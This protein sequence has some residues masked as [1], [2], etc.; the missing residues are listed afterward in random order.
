MSDA[1]LSGAAGAPA[2]PWLRRTIEV[3]FPF[4]VAFAMGALVLEVT[5]R[6]ALTTYV[7]LARSALGGPNEIAN[8]LVAATPIVLTGVA[9]A[10]AFR[11]GVFNV[12]VEGSV[13]VGAFAAAWIGFTA[14]ALPAPLLIGLA[15]L[16][17]CLAGLLWAVAPALV[18]VW[19]DVNEVVT[20]LM[21][22]YVAILLTSYLVNFHFLA[23][24]VAN[25]MSPLVA[26]HL[27]SI[28][29]PTQLTLAF[30]LAVAVVIAYGVLF[31]STT[32]GYAMR[33]VGRSGP[34]ARAS[35]IG[36]WRVVLAAMLL[37]GLVGG[38]AGGL[39]VLSV[40]Y[41][42][43][44]NF[45]PGYGFTGIAVAILGRNHPLGILAAGLFFGALTNGGAVVQLF[46]NVPIDLVNILQGTLMILAVLS[47]ARVPLLRRLTRDA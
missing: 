32:L 18:R 14:T 34:F 41:R 22:N 9:T 42:F 19:W 36:V 26:A 17:G 37:S 38:L 16:G 47:F 3:L 39:Q 28:L 25:S 24:G 23:R 12:G 43:I 13:Y 8:T 11:A 10:L 2:P 30:P 4:L 31:R 21:L 46:S 15:L 27:G 33:M 5:G 45:S 7:Q 44:D 1:A 29:P 40:N 6:D 20:T 35:G